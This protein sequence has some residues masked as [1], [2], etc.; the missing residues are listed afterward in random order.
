MEQ[1]VRELIIQGVLKSDQI[2][3][4][5]QNIHRADFV[6]VSA[7]HFAHIN[8]PLSIGFGQT[9][10]QPW[11]VAFMLELLNP[12]P[13]E[14]ILDVGSG[15]G[16]QTALLSF[17]V[18]RDSKGVELPKEKQGKVFGLERIPEL[19]KE[20]IKNLSK[21]NF[22]RKGVAEIHCLNAEF[23]FPKEAPFDKIIAAASAEEIPEK[24]KEELRNRG[25]LVAPIKSRIMRLLKEKGEFSEE[26]YEGFSF[27]PFI[28]D[29][30]SSH[31]K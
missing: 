6:P 16:W 3:S 2:I 28:K 29:E 14:K 9:I 19:A 31:E 30:K 11:T 15:S 26:F 1:L 7:K 17:C 13:G 18:S 23:G 20:S 27:V 24:W 10:S 8:E 22:L 25:I 21:Y 12:K 5:F 4:A